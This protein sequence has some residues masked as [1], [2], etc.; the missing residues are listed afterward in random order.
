MTYFAE[1]DTL[2]LIISEEDEAGSV[3]LTPMLQLN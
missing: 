1:N 3:E 2:Q